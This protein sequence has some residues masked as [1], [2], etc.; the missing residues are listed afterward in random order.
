[1]RK[2]NNSPAWTRPALIFA[3][4]N[5]ILLVCSLF[6]DLLAAAAVWGLS[7]YYIWQRGDEQ[8]TDKKF[9][10]Y[11]LIIFVLEVMMAI[12]HFLVA[13]AMQKHIPARAMRAAC[14]GASTVLVCAWVFFLVPQGLFS[15]RWLAV[16]PVAL[17]HAAG[18]VLGFIQKPEQNFLRNHRLLDQILKD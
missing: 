8:W 12:S 14:V 16:L 4:Y 10:Y 13:S 5:F 7:R 17:A 9:Y 18:G 15:S 11:A 1:M 2:A 6:A 3:L